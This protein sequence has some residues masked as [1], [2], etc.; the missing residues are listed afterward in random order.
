M[1]AQAISRAPV[2]AE[3][4]PRVLVELAKVSVEREGKPILEEVDLVVREGELVTL[5]GPN[6]AGKTT[7]VKVALGLVPPTSGKVAIQPGIRIGYAPQH[8]PIERTI[9]ID[10]L[11]FLA[12]AGKRPREDLLGVLAEVGLKGSEDRQLQALSGGEL[13]RLLLARALLRRPELLVLDEPLSG[14]DLNGQFELYELIAAIRSRY[15]CAVL[16]VSHDLHIVMAATDRVVCLDRCVRCTGSPE[17]VARDPRFA[18]LFGD[19][20]GRLVALYAHRHRVAEK[21]AAPVRTEP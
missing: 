6:G 19:R 20:F 8:L 12:L 10:A 1:L 11:G 7:L 14:V 9:P 13:R 18:G 17:A 5:I 4:P 16:L 21:P 15:R 3:A 2:A